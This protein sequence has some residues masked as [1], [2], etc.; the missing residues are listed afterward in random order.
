MWKI[1]I[2]IFLFFLLALSDIFDWKM[3]E[4][5]NGLSEQFA[6]NFLLID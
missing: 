6:I 4:K 5:I 2:I 3:T 1:V